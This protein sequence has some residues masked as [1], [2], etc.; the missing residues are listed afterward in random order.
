MESPQN[1]KLEK[2]KFGLW[3]GGH[4][5]ILSGVTIDDGAVVAASSV[6]TRWCGLASR[7]TGTLPETHRV[8]GTLPLS[9]K[10]MSG[11]KNEHR[12]LSRVLPFIGRRRGG[13]TALHS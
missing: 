12:G 4:S 2:S 8:S 13:K 5:T 11:A 10:P 6:V 9:R 3:I 7:R 1:S